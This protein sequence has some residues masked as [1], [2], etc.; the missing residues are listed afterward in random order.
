VD[1]QRARIVEDLSGSLQ[2]ELSCDPLTVGLYSTD[3]SLYEMA[4]LGVVFPKHRDDVQAVVKY[5][6]EQRIPIIPRGAGSGVAG[7]SLGRGL[8]ID[9]SRHMRQVEW[10]GEESV[11]VQPGA[12]CSQVNRQ[13]RQYGRYFPPDPSG[14]SVTTIGSMLALDA[15]GSHSV[16]VGST[17]DHVHSLEIVLASGECL[18]VCDE[19]LTQAPIEM[20]PLPTCTPADA[21][22]PANGADA[23]QRTKRELVDRLA[24]LLHYNAPLIAKHQPSLLRNR[25]GY[26]LHGALDGRKLRLGRMLVGSEGT[27]ALFTAA[28][29]HTMPLPAH[30]GVVLLLFGKMESALRS[31]T[32]ISA[33]QPSACDLLDRR[34]L[35][36]AREAH[37]RFAEMI[38]AEA[39]GAL[40]VEQTGFSLQQIQDRIRMVQVCLRSLPDMQ[41][42]AHDAYDEADVE[43]LWSLPERVVPLLAS[44]QGPTRPLPFVEDIAVPPEAMQ[45]FMVRAR[46]VLQ[47]HKLIAS[48]YAHAAA[49]Q[50]HIRPF[51]PQ[52][53][54]DDA[55][56]LEEISRDLYA[57]VFEVGGTIS[58]E[59]GVGLART[60]YVAQQYGPLYDVFR[61]VKELF[62][63]QGLLNPD[64]II[65]DDPHL[66][67]RN[68][69]PT[70]VESTEP[71]ALQLRWKPEEM[72]QS[73]SRCNGCGQ[74]RTQEPEVRMC[75]LF[76]IDP[77]E[78]AAPRAHANAM[79]LIATGRL[80]ADER[81]SAEFKRVADLCFNCKQCQLECPS[82]VDIP[83]MAIEAKAGYIQA[84]GLT[85]TDWVLSRAHSFGPLGS[86]LAD[87]INWCLNNPVARWFVEKFLGIARQR[88]LPAFSRRTFMRLIP[89]EILQR[90]A[91]RKGDQ[92]VVYFVDHYVNYHDPELGQ[93]FL[94]ILKHHGIAVHVPPEQLPSGMALI[95]AGDLESAR[96]VAEV[97]LRELAELARDGSTIVCT[98]PAA[99]LALTQEYPLLIDHPDVQLVASRVVEAG[100][101]LL[102][103]HRQNK[104]RVSEFKPL[105]LKL[106]YHTPCHLKALQQGTPLAELLG[107][108]PK[109]SLQKLEEGCSG[110]AGAFGMSSRNFKS[111]IR[112]GWGL[113][114]RMR[115]PEFTAGTTEC[116]SCKIQMEQGTRTP[117]LHP[118]KLLAL[119]WGL[120]PELAQKLK[121]S[122]RRLLV[123]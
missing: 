104:L 64:K 43:F 66:A 91:R 76:R 13:L 82:Q 26:I 75:P 108:I 98:E 72:L 121:A 123:T 54:P 36:L 117:T 57:A 23:A 47:K 58:G 51:L 95:S 28:T 17:R 33:L 78:Q 14:A 100:A 113:I 3:A 5:A 40:L 63:P 50:M 102:D 56:R 38:P 118:L 27:L 73:A 88:K 110:M 67:T 4:P 37:P 44:L 112:I 107:L 81:T 29:L 119:S 116:S 21:T 55:H 20:P 59:H 86:A 109:V 83:H 80:P 79:R 35:S 93:A 9:F 65:S 49:G 34:L 111:S 30:R 52:P 94:A 101:F 48:F 70:L 99:A 11:R 69:R 92:P 90:P 120:L 71:I 39:E 68:L 87:P 1:E 115:A 10:V 41:F 2:G 32:A 97:N 8:L 42:V 105:D 16:R 60:P 84:H 85:G 96:E 25:C 19:V 77:N 61:Q 24:W 7:E 114:N 22:R 106:A 53:T 103:L 74:C 45:D 122:R 31:V 46:A 15:A 12:V 62:D 6:S 89:R 18:E